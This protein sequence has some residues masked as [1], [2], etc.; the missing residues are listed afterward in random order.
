LLRS[1]QVFNTHYHS[2]GIQYVKTGKE[3]HL[4]LTLSMVYDRPLSTSAKSVESLSLA[5]NVIGSLAIF[6]C[7]PATKTVIKVWDGTTWKDVQVEELNSLRIGNVTEV[8]ESSKKLVFT[9][10]KY[11]GGE[12]NWH[13]V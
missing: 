8:S 1:K 9:P 11:M 4:K 3:V 6:P 10:M 5:K 2:A 7:H 13:T 12:I